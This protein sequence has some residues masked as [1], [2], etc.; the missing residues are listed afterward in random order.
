MLL[1]AGCRLLKRSQPQNRIVMIALYG[2]LCE[3]L[4]MVEA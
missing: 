1:F 2:D 4:L 3:L